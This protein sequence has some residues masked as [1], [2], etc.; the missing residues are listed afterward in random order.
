[1]VGV[2]DWHGIWME[3]YFFLQFL[4]F[5]PNTSPNHHH[6]FFSFQVQY[7]SS[8]VLIGS[9]SNQYFYWLNIEVS[10]TAH[11]FHIPWHLLSEDY[12]EVFQ[13]LIQLLQAFCYCFHRLLVTQLKAFFT[14]SFFL[15]SNFCS[16]SP[17]LQNIWL[18][19]F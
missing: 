8:I 13:S 14:V 4:L 10:A 17:Y 18:M 16:F 19:H 7:Q 9:S 6:I 2:S 12:F 1:M 11:S 5:F 3:N 15:Q